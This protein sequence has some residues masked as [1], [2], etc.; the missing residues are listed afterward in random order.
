MVGPTTEAMPKIPPKTPWIRDR[1]SIVKMSAIEANTLENRI[2]PKSPWIP[3][4]VTSWTMSCDSPHSHDATTKPTMGEQ[5]R[6]TAEEVA[7]L[8]GDRGHDRGRHEVR[9]EDPGVEVEPLELGDD[10]RERRPDD[11]LVQRR[12]EE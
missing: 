7:E 8:A 4:N 1:I 9:G 3:R 2:P 5:Q 6:L 12:E 10:P 11:R